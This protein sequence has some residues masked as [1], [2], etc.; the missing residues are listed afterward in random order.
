MKGRTVR[1]REDVSMKT[2]SNG[3]D[4][5]HFGSMTVGGKTHHDDLK[6]VDGEVVTGWWRR[7]GH[8][9]HVED[10]TDILAAKPETLVVGRGQPGWMRVSPTLR[11]TLEEARIELIDEPTQRAVVTF[12]R[13]VQ[14]G[15]R[16]AAAFHLTC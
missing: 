3:I 5:Y 6:I 8:A 14:E 11:S 1:P 2:N 4:E 16:V 9:V 15:K 10:V 13:L 12:N 7:E